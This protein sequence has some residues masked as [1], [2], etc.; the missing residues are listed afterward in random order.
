MAIFVSGINHQTAPV[1]IREKINFSVPEIKEII[2]NFI[3]GDMLKEAVVLST[4]NRTEIYGIVKDPANLNGY[5]PRQL[6]L[7]KG[8]KQVLPENIMYQKIDRQAVNHLFRVASGLDSLVVGEAQILGQTKQ[9][10]VLATEADSSGSILNKLFHHSFRTAK[11]VRTE[12]KLGEGS[13]SIGSVAV[14]LAQKLYRDFSDKNVVM[15]GAGEIAQQTIAHLRDSG[16][17]AIFILNRTFE[18]AQELAK[19][20]NGTAL[21]YKSLQEAL[22]FAD[23]I[24]TSTSASKPILDSDTIKKTMSLRK[25]KPLFLIDIAVPRNIEPE[26]KEIYNVF[27]FNIDD[28]REVVNLNLNDR[29]KEIPKA[30]K[31]IDLEVNNFMTWYKS[32]DSI[33]TIQQLQ[34]HFEILRKHEIKKNMKYFDENDRDNIDKFSKS[35]LKKILHSPIM[36]LKAC[37]ESGNVCLRCNVKDLFGLEE[38]CLTNE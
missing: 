20:V 10:Y 17:K 24:I 5:I 35:L 3:S 37:P 29:K 1:E 25:N 8:L 16:S 26:V 12:T 30:E 11:Q 9:S 38:Q 22:I 6:S 19:V 21:P 23:V 28:L 27:L 18:K 32:L 31:I 34:E 14:N 2:Q 36:R 13:V 15:I 7:I 4:C 33:F